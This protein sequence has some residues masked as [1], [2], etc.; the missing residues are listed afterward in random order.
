M[1]VDRSD[2]LIGVE[3]KIRANADRA[4]LDLKRHRIVNVRH[5][6][7]AAVMAVTLVRN[8]DAEAIMKA[9]C[10]PTV[11]SPKWCRASDFAPRGA[12]ATSS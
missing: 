12:S 11:C 5:S 9:A 6:H 7:E 10:V 1:P 2:P 3:G 8:G 4:A